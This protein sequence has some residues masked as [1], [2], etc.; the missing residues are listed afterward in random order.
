[1]ERFKKIYCRGNRHMRACHIRLRNRRCGRL[2]QHIRK[3]IYP[4]RSGV[5]SGYSCNGIQYR[6]HFQL[7]HQPCS[8]ARNAD[9][10]TTFVDRLCRLCCIAVN[11][12][13]SRLCNPWSGIRLRL[14]IRRKP[15]SVR[16]GKRLCRRCNFGWNCADIC[17]RNRNNRSYEQD[18]EHSG[19]GRCNRSDT[20]ACTYPRHCSYRH[21][22][23][24]CKKLDAR[25]FCRRR[26]SVTGMD[27]HCC[28]AY[29][30]RTCGCSLQLSWKEKGLIY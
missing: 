3:R 24:P 17:I 27:F 10:Q 16:L 13:R 28:S 29:R 26:R 11:R 8:F 22:G 15:N 20:D 18:G 1:M 23:Q 4:N 7:S 6:Q 9:S 5:R 25:N 30:W 19:F 14:R 2:Q 21:I 12:L